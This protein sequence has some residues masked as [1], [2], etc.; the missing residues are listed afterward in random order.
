MVI[1]MACGCGCG[2]KKDG[3]TKKDEGTKKK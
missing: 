1:Y 2:T 3:S